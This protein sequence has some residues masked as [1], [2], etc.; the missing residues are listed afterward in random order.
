[1]P[2]R[3]RKPAD[4]TAVDQTPTESPEAKAVPLETPEDGQRPA[5]NAGSKPPESA[6]VQALRREREGYARSGRKERAGAVDAELKR[7]GAKPGP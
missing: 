2:P 4:E 7:A 5:E 3:T 1:M 6:Y